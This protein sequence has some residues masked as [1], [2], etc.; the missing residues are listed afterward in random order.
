MAAPSPFQNLMTPADVAS[1][2]RIADALGTQ[3]VDAS[4]VQH[5]TQALAR[6]VQGGTAGYYD[7]TAGAGEKD[8]NAAIAKALSSDGSFGKLSPGVQGIISQDPKLMQSVV[9]KVVANKLDPQAGLRTALMNEQVAAMRRQAATDAE[10]QPYKR[11]LMEAQAQLAQAN[12]KAAGQKDGHKLVTVDG[13]VVR[14]APD[15]TAEKVYG[16]N[17]VETRRQQLIAA[18]LN[19]DEPRHQTYM[20]V[21]KLPKEDQAPLTAAD[22]KAILEADEMVMTGQNVIRSLGEAIELS[23]KAYTGPT[24]GGRGYL[25]SFAGSENAKATEELRNLITQ[26]ALTQLKATFGAAPTEGE[27]KIL[28]DIQGSV[29]LEPSVR[30]KIYQRAQAMAER[31]LN[32]YRDRANQMRGQTYYKPRDGSRPASEAPDLKTKYGLE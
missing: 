28:L 13:Q 19:P 3:A 15:G 32:F 20:A 12:A 23:K 14:I 4:P 5:W 26:N 1:R 11:Q 9:G 7:S 8:R 21:G 17:P 25:M 10:M 30:E 16:S 6:V 22:K 29:N 24:A 2:R 27:R 18:G 31:R